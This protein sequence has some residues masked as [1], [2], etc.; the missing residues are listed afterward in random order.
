[1]DKVMRRRDFLSAIGAMAFAGVANGK[2]HHNARAKSVIYLFMEGGPSQ[3]D[4]F[5]YKAALSKYQGKTYSGGLQI[6]SNGRKVGLLT[7]SAFSFHPRGESGLQVSSLYPHLAKFADDLCV[8][9]SMYC[10]TPT[11]SPGILQMNTGSIVVGRPSLGLSL[12]HI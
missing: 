6:G 3:V 10:D 11:H 4:T 9:R 2:G 12:I 1:M 7:P 8:I 5:D